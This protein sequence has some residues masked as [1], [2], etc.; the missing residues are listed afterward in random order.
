MPTT[1]RTDPV[2]NFKFNVQAIMGDQ[3]DPFASMGFMSV[4]GIAMNT[5]MVAYREGGYNTS[6]HKLPGQTDFSPLTMSAG[7]IFD[8][9][10]MWNLARKMF[11]VQWGGGS[12]GF[13]EGNVDEFRY[14]LIVRVLGHPV[15]LGASDS[16]KGGAISGSVLAYRFFNCWTASVGFTGLNASGNEIVVQQMTVHHEG[17]EVFFGNAQAVAAEMPATVPA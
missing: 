12:L 1:A 2:R 14:D 17:F 13:R 15:T 3:G 10:F 16:G 9:P 6:P 11:S 8:K 4:E 5:E 7:V